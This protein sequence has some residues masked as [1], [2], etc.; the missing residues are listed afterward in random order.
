MVSSS[1]QSS[2]RKRE[3]L[4]DVNQTQTAAAADQNKTKQ[5]RWEGRGRRRGGQGEGE[6]SGECSSNESTRRGKTDGWRTGRGKDSETDQTLVLWILSV[7]G[8]NQ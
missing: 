5:H 6:R 3:D 8:E 7:H 1:L 2:F 4:R